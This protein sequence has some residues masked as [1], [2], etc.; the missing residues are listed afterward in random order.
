MF[1]LG[2]LLRRAEKVVLPPP[3]AEHESPVKSVSPARDKYLTACGAALPYTP[4]ER[5]RTL[6]PNRGVEGV[7]VGFPL[8]RTDS[9]LN[10]AQP[11]TPLVERRQRRTAAVGT[12]TGS[13]DGNSHLGGEDGGLVG[14]LCEASATRA[15][16]QK[17]GR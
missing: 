12:N 17:A 5:P 2:S 1:L 3:P 7:D 16:L 14:C 6:N 11:R 15:R 8:R 4:K 13:V 10:V 9:G